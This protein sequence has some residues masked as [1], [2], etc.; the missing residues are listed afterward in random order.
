VVIAFFFAEGAG[1]FFIGGRFASPLLIG[2]VHEA[3]IKQRERRK[4]IRIMV[5]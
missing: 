1:A 4:L 3:R 5:G 2:L